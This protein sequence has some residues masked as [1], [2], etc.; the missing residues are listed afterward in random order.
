MNGCPDCEKLTHG[1]CGQHNTHYYSQEYLQGWE[2][3]KCGSI[4]SPFIPECGICRMSKVKFL[5]GSTNG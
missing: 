5:V 1:D 2:C 4:Y 3:P